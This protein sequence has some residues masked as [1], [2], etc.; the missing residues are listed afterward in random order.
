MGTVTL[1]VQDSGRA[2]TALTYTI[3]GTSP[4][5]NVADTFTFVNDGRVAVIFQKSGANPCTVT[6]DTPG[7]VDGLAIAQRTVTVAAGTSDV[8]AN[9]SF[10]V[11]GPFPPTIYNTPG[12]T[13]LSGFTVSEVTGLSC[14]VVRVA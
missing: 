9:T 5:L 12:T 4:L 2:G 11:C 6:F 7:T 3:S 1:A 14:R 13:M 8:I 10:V